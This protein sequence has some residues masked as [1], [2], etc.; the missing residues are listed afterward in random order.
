MTKI[1]ITA[2][3][4]SLGKD[5]IFYAGLDFS[6]CGLPEN[7]WALQWNGT[8]GHIEYNGDDPNEPIS[9]LPAWVSACVSKWDARDYAEKNPPALT[10]QE[11]IDRNE[12]VAKY[13]IA[14]C[15]WTQLS[16]VS[17]ANKAEWDAYRSALRAIATNPTE[18]PSWPTKPSVQWQ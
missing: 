7:L 2:E 9:S 4:A 6:D 8:S 18:N 1:V 3:D 14:Q 16:D 15:D 5:G 11:L 17:L 12:A 13:E 10:G